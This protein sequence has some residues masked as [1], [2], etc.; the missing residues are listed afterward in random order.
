[1]D[2]F[3]AP[4]ESNPELA[5]RIVFV[6]GGAFSPRAKEFLRATGNA[7]V[8]KPFDPIE[9]RRIVADYIGDGW[10]APERRPRRRIARLRDAGRSD[11]CGCGLK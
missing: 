11:L 5:R 8:A 9:L 4:R 6:T 2:F 3:D 7:V 10:P 1:M